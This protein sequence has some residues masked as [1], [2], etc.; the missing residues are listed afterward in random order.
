[1]GTWAPKSEKFPHGLGPVA[2]AIHAAGMKFL[3][4]FERERVSKGSRIALEHPE[5]VIGPIIPYGGLMNWGVPE[6]ADWLTDLI[7]DQIDKSRIDIF[8][9]DYN[10]ESLDYWQ[11]NDPP[12]RQGMTEIRFVEGM[13][14]IW[15]ELRAG[16]PGLWI[17]N[18]ASGGRLIDLET[19]MRAIPLWES[20]LQIYGP[21]P[22]GSPIAKGWLKSLSAHAC[23]WRCG[24]RAVL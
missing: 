4:W 11:R 19:T 15:D 22:A 8:R 20:D 13:Y 9:A 2:D 7:S 16:H 10:M 5:W 21:A 6:A 3:V 18:C 17:D 1:M 12:D 14:R 23:W 24:C